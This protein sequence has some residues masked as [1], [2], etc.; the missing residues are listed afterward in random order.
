MPLTRFKLSAIADGGIDTDELADGAVTL[1]KLSATGTKDSTT[2][3]RGDNT[4]QEVSV[5]P[6][7]VSDQ[8]NT[9]TGAFDIPSGTT[10]ER[11]GSPN[12]GYI[13]F[14]TDDSLTE[15]YDG[16]EWTSVGATPASLS[17]VTGTIYAGLESTLTLTG[18]GFLDANLVV[19]FSQSSDGIDED[20][21]GGEL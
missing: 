16:T 14:N 4:F 20:K 19:N 9:S 10:A 13:R 18:A 6:T 15:I 17:S 5:T 1:A 21:L 3:L 8:S 7:A 12:A 2:F 11:P